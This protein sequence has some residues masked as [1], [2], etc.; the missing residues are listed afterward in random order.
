MSVPDYCALKIEDL[1]IRDWYSNC[2]KIDRER[3]RQSDWLRIPIFNWIVWYGHKICFVSPEHLGTSYT[4]SETDVCV[5]ECV[6]GKKIKESQCRKIE[7]NEQIHR[8]MSFDRR[9][10]FVGYHRLEVRLQTRNLRARVKRLDESLWFFEHNREVLAH[11]RC[12]I[13]L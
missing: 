10:T 6:G 11:N 1:W 5:F 12:D 9:P 2:E 13:L 4:W 8:Y 7:Q 3:L